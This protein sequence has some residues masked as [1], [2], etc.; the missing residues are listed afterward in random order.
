MKHEHYWLCSECAESKGGVFPEGHCCTCIVGECPYCKAKDI[1][2]IPWVDFN[3][4]K[5][6]AN[7]RIAKNNRD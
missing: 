3:W 2:L 4:P 7:D 6:V 1:M 5:D